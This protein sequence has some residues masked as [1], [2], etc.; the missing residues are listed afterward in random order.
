M[1]VFMFLSSC[2][3]CYVVSGGR[4]YFLHGAWA[5]PVDLQLSRA[6]TCR[7]TVVEYVYFVVLLKLSRASWTFVDFVQVLVDMLEC[8][9]QFA[10]QFF[11]KV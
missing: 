6:V 2:I 11:S 9:L 7:H 8:D 3:I 1:C 10:V 5:D 4:Q